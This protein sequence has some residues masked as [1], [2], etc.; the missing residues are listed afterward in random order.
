MKKLS[1]VKKDPHLPHFWNIFR[2]GRSFGVSI[3]PPTDPRSKMV[4]HFSD[5]EALRYWVK[6]DLSEVVSPDHVVDRTG[7]NLVPKYHSQWY[8]ENILR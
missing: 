5:E 6:Y 1:R 7:L 4:R 2:S 8:V 3:G